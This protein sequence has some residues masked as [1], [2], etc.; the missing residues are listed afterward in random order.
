VYRCS[1]CQGGRESSLRG[2]TKYSAL[3]YA[4][5]RARDGITKIRVLL[6]SNLY[7]PEPTGVG[8]YSHGLA[9]ALVERGHEVTTI[10]AVPSYPHWKRFGGYPKWSWS[11]SI[12]DGVTVYRCPVYVPGTVSGA[13]RILHYVSYVASALVPAIWLA[14][15]FRPDVVL[16]IVPTLLAAPVALATAK[17]AGALSWLHVQ[18][19]EVEAGFATD[20]MRGNSGLARLAL[21]FEHKCINAFDQTST[22]SPEMCAKLV[23]KGRAPETVHEVRNWA[24]LIEVKPL[25]GSKFRERWGVTTPHVA[26]YSGSIARKQGIEIIIDVARRFRDE[27][28]ITFVICGNGPNRGELEQAASDLTNVRFHDLQPKED[29][30]ELVNLASIHLLPQRR[31]AAD[32]VLPSKLTNMLAS[33]RPV[34]AG[35]D[36]GSGLAR[37][38]EGC[39]LAVEPESVTALENAIRLLMQDQKLHARFS[40]EARCRAEERWSREAII[41]KFELELIAATVKGGR[42]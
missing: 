14:R 24:E 7:A 33:G 25:L 8:P 30:P 26:L 18:D 4:F 34:I 17:L 29:L 37:E 3:T 41:N 6:F 11:R 40:S 9:K 27:S 20:Q 23:E 32:L 36:A 21:A 5:R 28:D 39:G 10:A 15:S 13:K 19:F 31:N 38:V 12:E 2:G 22:I 1:R 42:L 16:H 35:A